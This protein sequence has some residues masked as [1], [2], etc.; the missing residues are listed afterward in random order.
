[1]LLCFRADLVAD[2]GQVLAQPFHGVTSRESD[3]GPK[4]QEEQASAR[5]RVCEEGRHRH[6]RAA[7]REAAAGDRGGNPRL[8]TSPRPNFR[9]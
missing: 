6:D 2:G 7:G 4:Q 3:A 5:Q 9:P 8:G 1:M